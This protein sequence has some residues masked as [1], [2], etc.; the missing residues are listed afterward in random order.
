MDREEGYV[1]IGVVAKR[2]GVHPQT[3]G[4]AAPTTCRA[5]S[6]TATCMPRQMP[7]YGTR[8]SR[9]ARGGRTG[10]REYT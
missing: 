3:K 6:E 4:I 8:R 9:A 10:N 1:F 2:F 5:N 7:R